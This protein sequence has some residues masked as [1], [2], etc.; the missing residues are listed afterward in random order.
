MAR[1]LQM[2]SVAA[3]A[4]HAIVNEWILAE[5]DVFCEGD[6][7]AMIETDKAVVELFAEA[8]GVIGKLLVGPG[9]E[10][11]VGAPIAL[12][13]DTETE[14]PDLASL[15]KTIEIGA[16]DESKVE[17]AQT[18]SKP[19]A[20]TPC[21][22]DTESRVFASPLA[23]RLAIQMGLDLSTI[24]GSGPNGRIVK[25]DIEKTRATKQAGD[26]SPAG[27]PADVQEASMP[28]VAT[29][30]QSDAPIQTG[31][32]ASG[33]RTVPHTNMRKTIA[34]RLCESTSMV[35]HFYLTQTI[36]VDRLLALR[37]EVNA[38]LSGDDRISINDF[39]IRAVAVALQD[40]P[41]ANVRW[42][43]NE[44]HHFEHADVG[45]AVSTETGLITPIVR[46]ANTKTV[47]T[48][49][50]EMTDLIRRA[51]TGQLK[52]EEYQGGSFGISNMGMYGIESFS[53][54]INPPQAGILAVGAVCS[55]PVIQDGQ[56]G[57]ASVLH[58]TLSVDHRAMDGAV[59]AQWMKRLQHYLEQ[60]LAML[61]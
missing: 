44:M 22:D 18:D 50:R 49:R 35:P 10:V 55:T 34:R 26:A 25:V 42:T 40:V 28:D 17:A 60:P 21:R 58:A 5:D 8:A 59:A 19:D 39:I 15:L 47:S 23:R 45:V 11:E 3:N 16:H 43:D 31:T 61:L 53:A 1:V 24:Q 52:P 33:Y 20:L 9:D 13:L 51:K 2:P 29:P 48:I 41:Q 57:V 37:E 46:A 14:K 30:F 7:I 12:L 36:H 27:Q 38:S 32:S 6:C 54:I 4:T 56:V